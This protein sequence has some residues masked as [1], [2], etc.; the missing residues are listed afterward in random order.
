MGDPVDGWTRHGECVDC[1]H[2]CQVLGDRL[3]D[4][5]LAHVSDT[6]YLRVRGYVTNGTTARLR[7]FLSS[8]CPQLNVDD[9]GASACRIYDDRPETCANFP[10]D[11]R[12]IAHTPCSYWFERADGLKIGGSQSP[13]PYKET[14]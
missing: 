14:A 5:D 6:E 4:I 12:Q 7:V 1:G 3:H 11:P 2:C 9:S 13:H 8:P 10:R